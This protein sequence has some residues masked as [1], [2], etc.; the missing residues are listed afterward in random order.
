MTP[1]DE[2]KE[3][4]SLRLTVAAGGGG[5]V[6][7]ANDGYCGIAVQKDAAYELSLSARAATAL[8]VL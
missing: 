4:P 3:P 5:R 7:V 1:A 8:Q 6:G 2:R